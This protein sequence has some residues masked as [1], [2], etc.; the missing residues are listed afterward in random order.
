MTQAI[1][2]KMFTKY[3][4]SD[5]EL[6]LEAA[7]EIKDP[8]FFAEFFKGNTNLLARYIAKLDTVFNNENM[9]KFAAKD[10]ARQQACRHE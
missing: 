1:L 7:Q 8:D 6:A 10:R 2:K 4:V 5:E 9:A 3:A